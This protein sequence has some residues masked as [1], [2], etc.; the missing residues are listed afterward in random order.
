MDFGVNC[1]FKSVMIIKCFKHHLVHLVSCLSFFQMPCLPQN[2]PGGKL[3]VEPTH[4]DKQDDKWHKQTKS[5][6]ILRIA[7][8]VCVFSFSFCA[9]LYHSL[10]VTITNE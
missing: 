8:C 9:L 1:H 2:I 7:L 6:F 3:N 4:T 10:S 5:S